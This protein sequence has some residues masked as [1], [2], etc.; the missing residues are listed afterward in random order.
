MLL[1]V[2]IDLIG[3]LL[4]VDNGIIIV[5][6]IILIIVWKEYKATKKEM[7][8]LNTAVRADAVA[9]IKIIDNLTF[10]IAEHSEN[11]DK[12]LVTVTES[13]AIL[14]SH[15]IRKVTKDDSIPTS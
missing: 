6:A 4:Q 10:T 14:K 3:K 1:Q 9:N 7:S 5:L 15:E 2:E 8:D 13:L 12:R 11:S